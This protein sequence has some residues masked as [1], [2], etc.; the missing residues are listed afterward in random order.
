[1]LSVY[2][3]QKQV[4][5]ETTACSFLDKPFNEPLVH[6]AVVS[7]LAG[8]RQGTHAQKTRAQV[9]G[10]GKKPWRQKGTGNARAGTIRSPLWRTGGVVF[11]KTNRDYS[12]KL[13]KKM[14]RGAVHSIFA[15]LHRQQ[16]LFTIAEL[17]Q[18]ISK[19]KEFLKEFSA[20][21]VKDVRKKIVFVGTACPVTFY[22][23]IRNLR[24]V[25]YVDATQLDLA[26]LVHADYVLITADALKTIEGAQ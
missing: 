3:S 12:V 13:N 4:V 26:L 23:S 21:D 8:A 19:T 20:F 6:Q 15:E 1:M 5:T 7:Y 25:E 10:G 16:R 18:S 11:A 9:R 14:Y 22:L 2:N 17:S 24:N